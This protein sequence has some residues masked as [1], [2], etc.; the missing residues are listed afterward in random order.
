MARFT[1]VLL[2]LATCALLALPAVAADPEAGTVSGA[3]PTAEWT[4]EPTDPSSAAYLAAQLAE[5]AAD[6]CAAPGS[7]CDTFTLTVAP[8]GGT[9]LTVTA[10]AVSADDFVALSVTDPAGEESFTATDAQSETIVIENPA[11]GDYT[12]QVLGSPFLTTSVPYAG[13]AT[14]EGAPGA[15]P[16][17]TPTPDPTPAPTP[18]PTPEP[19]P[20]PQPAAPAPAAAPAPPVALAIQPDRRKLRRAARFGFRTRVVCR[21]GCTKVKL[22]AYVSSLTARTL[23][24]GNSKGDVEVG[25]ARVLRNAEGR[26]LAAVT[27]KPSMRRRIARARRLALAIEA[28]ATDPGGRV[29]TVTKRLTLRR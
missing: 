3:T 8:G 12:V 10:T 27:F 6:A 24:L 19:Q 23:R 21:G 9:T 17:A 4:G 20:Q 18:A 25:S 28:T 7:A 26:R 1:V 2:T 15:E 22:R 14:L 13:K 29:R 11:E 16:T 5:S